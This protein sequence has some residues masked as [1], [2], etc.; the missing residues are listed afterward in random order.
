MKTKEILETNK[1]I[2]T[3]QVLEDIGDTER[4][5]RE[6]EAEASHLEATPASSQDYKLNNYRASAKRTG[7]EDR[8][9]FVAN[10]RE[11]IHARTEAGERLS[12]ILERK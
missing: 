10:L 9:K 2:P 6:L 4:E 1:H 3:A 7:I 8:K 11:L 12:F 5:I